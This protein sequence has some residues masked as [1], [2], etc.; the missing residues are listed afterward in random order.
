[1][2]EILFNKFFL[3]LNFLRK[4]EEISLKFDGFLRIVLV[5]GISV[6]HL[7][8]RLFLTL[9]TLFRAFCTGFCKNFLLF[10]ILNLK[11]SKNVVKLQNFLQPNRK[12]H[13]KQQT[14]S[15]NLFL[16]LLGTCHH[17]TPFHNNNL[18]EIFSSSAFLS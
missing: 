13:F 12:P 7:I 6:F 4:E 16:Y 2:T 15:R 14:N 5:K 17:N 9:M 8:L 3:N 11:N 10:F 18:S 1:M